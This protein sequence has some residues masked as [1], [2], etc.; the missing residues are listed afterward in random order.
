MDEKTVK[1]QILAFLRLHGI[2]CWPNDS[3]GLFDTKRKAFRSA[4]HKLKGVSDI[5][6]VLPDGKI[7]CIEVKRP[8]SKGKAAGVL[9]VY[10]E[11]FI[12]NV[13][14]NNGIAF[15]AKSLDD[16]QSNLSLYLRHGVPSDDL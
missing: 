16:V 5:L 13:L 11:F 1:N 12:A 8:K 2:F 7:L 15:M 6:G 4:K 3:V 14:A 10:Q 9:S